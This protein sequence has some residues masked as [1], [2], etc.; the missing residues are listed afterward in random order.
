M[1]LEQ[2]IKN[3]FLKY[4]AVLGVLYLTLTIISFYLITAISV[5]P[6]VFVA[7][8][9]F[10]RLCLPIV[11]TIV[12]CFSGRKKIGGLWTFKQATTGIFAMF[13]MAFA[14]QFIGK[15]IVF[16]KFIEPNGV[17]KIQIAAIKTKSSNLQHKGY[18]Q[19]TID[20][21]MAEMKKDLVHQ[22]NALTP[23]AVIQEVIF[24]ILFIFLFALIF[25]SLF[26]NAEYVSGSQTTNQRQ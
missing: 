20:K 12:L 25:G 7:L 5:S 4:G 19:K 8:P 2:R 24:S 15:D 16:D 22:N 1:D 13:L 26:K 10:S 14:I 11:I 23:G 18:D 6:I 17:R 3:I 9:I 21:E